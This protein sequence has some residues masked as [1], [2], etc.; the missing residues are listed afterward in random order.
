ML[1]TVLEQ[2]AI[3]G[4][5]VVLLG[6]PG[7]A[8]VSLLRIRA[9][10][11]DTLAV[12]A[13]ALLGSLVA[14][15]AT[16]VQLGTSS[17]VWVAVVAHAVLSAVLVGAAVLVHRRR[18]AADALTIPAGRG[19]SKT[20]TIL[21]LFAGAFAWIVR[22]TI[23]LDGLYHVALSRKLVELSEPTF[24]NINRFADG[25]PNPVYALPGWHALVGWSGSLVGS[26]PIIAWE[27]MPVLVV[28]LGALAAGGLAR[29]VLATPRAE[30]VGVLAWIL[31]R[32]LF[33]RREVDGDAILFGAV[34]GQVTFE[35]AIPVVLAGV[36]VALV[37]VD[38]RA[39]RAA[40]AVTFA[41]IIA[42]VV[43]HA[44]YL[45]YVAIIGLGYAAWW[46]TISRRAAARLHDPKRL[47]V[48]GGWVAAM[49]VACF[50]VLVPLL[51]QLENFGNAPEGDRIDYHLGETL[52]MAHVRG[53]H[54]FEM[55]GLPG[56]LAI[57]AVPL[58]AWR[59]RNR[60]APFAI[61]S[62]GLLALLSFSFV[63][64][65]FQ[66]LRATGSLTLLLR[67][68]HAIGILLI[69]ALAALVLELADWVLARGWSH[70]R[71]QVWG[72]IVVVAMAAV[73]VV[74]GYDRFMTDWPGYVAWVGLLGVFVVAAV[75][76]RAHYVPERR[77][78]TDETGRSD[79]GALDYVPE[80]RGETDETGRSG[81]NAGSGAACRGL[82]ASTAVVLTLGLLL[83]VG[84]ISVRR[85]LENRDDF[86]VA[87]DGLAQGD[88]RCIGGPVLEALQNVPAGSVVL[89]DP[90][91]SFRAMAVAPVYVVGDYKV[92]NAATSDNRAEERLASINRF[93][94]SSR[95]DKERLQILNDQ[96][97]DYVLLD[98][99]D[100]RWLDA[101]HRDSPS[102]NALE[103][104][105][106]GLDSFAD[107]QAYDG[108]NTARL[109]GRFDE[110]FEQVAV[111][112]R[113]SESAIPERNPD[114]DAPC[115]SYGL[116]K[117]EQFGFGTP[118]SLFREGDG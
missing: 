99:Q 20:T 49:S 6:V 10:L 36:A 29:V 100:G 58:L 111:D 105:W 85:A 86:V 106:S 75:R 59:Y 78:E 50:A 94:D 39:R 13:G 44:N 65:L 38:S 98:L 2:A 103:R 77:G 113:A 15:V 72:A 76:P 23:S 37:S 31:A 88:L 56:M 110:A 4:V 41:G 28:V 70:R 25:G 81:W 79:D 9:A 33:A 48:V 112:D 46:F 61:L 90:V 89:S 40:L 45:P 115:N 118:E 27:I 104:A 35:L 54:A 18:R 97:V 84:A 96:G 17:R 24:S 73:G 68:N 66:L 62:G 107:V 1:S 53:G 3:L 21:A 92:W 51:A 83:P 60:P 91:A 102:T 69:V 82:V 26:D 12:P 43:Y 116:W 42:I 109:M 67:I 74:L 7:A 71:R 114:V 19:W 5:A 64:P 87:N 32:V 14:C 52:G 34:P 101:E 8:L 108:G 16:A 93:F 63:P 57:L 22:G 47:L 80:R 117:V 30:A 95:P 11:P 55:L